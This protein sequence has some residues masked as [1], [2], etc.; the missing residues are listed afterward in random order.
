M[1]E[2]QIRVLIAD[3]HVLVRKGLRALLARE[4]DISVI[5]EASDGRAAIEAAAQLQPDVILMDL[6]MP[7]LDGIEATRAISA[8]QPEIRILVLT[9]FTTDD[10]VFP[11]LKAGARGYLLKDSEPEALTQALRQVYRGESSL[12]P[13]IARKV[14]QELTSPAPPPAAP[15]PEPL[16]E[17]EIEVL[18]LIAQGFSNKEIAARLVI[19]EK[20]ART[21]VSNILHKLQ[22]ASRTQA[23]LYALREGLVSL[24]GD[25]KPEQP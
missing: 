2:P 8:R 7:E 24:E 19:T 21:H 20:T 17:R 25:E 5:G 12:H 23:T 15:T 11:A 1:S 10:K 16:T 9:S 13:A 18:R 3:D 14:L 22:L 6:S 4:P